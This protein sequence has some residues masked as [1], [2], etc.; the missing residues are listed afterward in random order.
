MNLPDIDGPCGGWNC[1]WFFMFFYLLLTQSEIVFL[2][3]A[4]SEVAVLCKV[5][6]EKL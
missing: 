6:L 5:G 2:W 1:E 4:C 3:F